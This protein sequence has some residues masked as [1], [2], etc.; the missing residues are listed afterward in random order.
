MKIATWNINSI[1][2]RLERLLAWL[3]KAQPDVLCLQEL[4]VADEAF[5]YEAIRQAG[6]HVAVFGQKTY[7]GVAILS[8]VEAQDIRRGM[9]AFE[10]PQ[11]RLLAAEVN[12]IW[13]VNA[14]VPNGETVGSEK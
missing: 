11:A 9:P 10:D 6:Y 8:R 5:P 2:A 14:Y 12:G 7:N 3:Q 4:K 13:I 1:R